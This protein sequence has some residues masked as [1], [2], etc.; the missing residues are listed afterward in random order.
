MVPKDQWVWMPHPAHFICSFD[1]R[2]HLAT[3]VGDF[4][5]STVG[6]L[7]HDE[8]VREITAEVRKIRLSGIG[9]ARKNDYMKKIGFEEI[10]YG[11][12]Y[13]TMVFK[14]AKD[15]EHPC[16]PWKIESGREL[17]FGGYNKPEDAYAG[18]LSMCEKVARGEIDDQ[19]NGEDQ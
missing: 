3:K 7:F 10:G 2:F 16:C 12:K 8:P 9:D 19:Q 17:D 6:E 5:V 4:I 15:V 14:A 11:R 13:E 18:H 1:C